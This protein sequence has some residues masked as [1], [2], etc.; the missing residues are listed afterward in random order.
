MITLQPC[1]RPQYT[2]QERPRIDKIPKFVKTV[3][4][5][6]LTGLKFE[7]VEI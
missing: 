2:G 5:N 1:H 4:N 7:E 3:E 6:G